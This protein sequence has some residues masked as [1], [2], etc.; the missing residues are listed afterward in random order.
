[1][2]Y[3]LKFI[4]YPL[5]IILLCLNI[6]LFSC[7]DQRPPSG[8]EKDITPPKAKKIVPENYTTNFHFDRIEITF[9]EFIK[10]NSNGGN[11]IISPKLNKTPK[12]ELLGKKLKIIFQEILDNNTTYI[13]NFG[14]SIKDYNEGNEL[15]N[16]KYVFSTGDFIDSISIKGKTINAFDKTGLKE[17]LIGLYPEDEDSFLLKEPTYFIK[18]NEQGEFILENIKFGKYKIAALQDKNLNYIYDQESE[19]IGFLDNTINIDT[20][21]N[22]IKIELFN[23]IKESKI[24]N[25]SNKEE[26]HIVFNFTKAFSKLALDISTYKESDVFYYSLDKKQ[27]HYYYN[28]TDTLKTD[29]YF[30]INNTEKDSFSLSLKD[31]ESKTINYTSEA[32]IINNKSL[33]NINFNFP[34]SETNKKNIVLQNE[35]KHLEYTYSWKNNNKKLEIQTKKEDTIYLTIKE[36]SFISFHKLTNT[37]SIDTFTNIKKDISTLTIKLDVAENLILELYNK[38]KKLISAD[39]VSRETIDFKNMKQGV[40][41]IRLYKDKNKNNIWDN[42]NLKNKTQAEKTL[43]Y[44]QIEIKANWDNEIK[45]NY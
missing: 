33:I 9:D 35:K 40:Y 20:N 32:Q 45:L 25:Y 21:I 37:N 14:N 10:F 17:I 43:V 19:M 38:D 18:T 5:V 24:K 39:I 8:G 22:N 3:K 4:S 31:G 12:F 27:F 26:N 34:I 2:N 13:I 23:N 15:N 42:G 1:M 7:A 29:F 41:Y 16:F 6:L 28:N 36:N 44:K 30:S 11:I